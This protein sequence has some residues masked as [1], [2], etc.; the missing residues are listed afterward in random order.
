MIQ[1]KCKAI[2]VLQGELDLLRKEWG[3]VQMRLWDAEKA[4]EGG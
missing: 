1:E 4:K 3:T 2:E